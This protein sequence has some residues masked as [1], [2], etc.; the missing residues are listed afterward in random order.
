MERGGWG[1]VPRG[2]EKATSEG[3]GAERV[4]WRLGDWSPG[5]VSAEDSLDRVG[6]SN[7][8]WNVAQD[9]WRGGISDHVHGIIC[10]IDIQRVK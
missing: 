3:P 5:S 1:K 7:R 8:I 10:M 2:Q 6:F 4:W 9:W